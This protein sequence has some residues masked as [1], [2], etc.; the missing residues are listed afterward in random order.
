MS[1]SCIP[2]SSASAQRVPNGRPEVV[3]ECGPAIATVPD[4]D[5]RLAIATLTVIDASTRASP[6]KNGASICPC[7]PCETDRGPPVADRSEIN[8]ARAVVS[9][10]QRQGEFGLV[11]G[12]CYLAI[13]DIRAAS[14]IVLRTRG[15]AAKSEHR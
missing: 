6:V 8:A 10:I 2:G 5:P 12:T 14:G 3:C 1:A 15:R 4:L 13:M 7:I 9:S 11:G